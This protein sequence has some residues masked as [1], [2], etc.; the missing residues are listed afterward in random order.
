[1]FSQRDNNLLE[2]TGHFLMN[3]LGSSRDDE[4]KH[5]FKF[6]DGCSKIVDV[7]CGTGTFMELAP[8]RMSGIDFNPENIEVCKAKGLDAQVG[9]ALSIP[10]EDNS[11]DGAYC[12]HLMQVFLPHQAAKLMSELGRVVKPGGKIIIVTLNWFERFFRHP[13]NV[14]AYP[15]DAIHRYFARAN[16]SQSPM[17]PGIPKMRQEGIWLRR[18]PLFELYSPKSHTLN[19]IYGVIS[20]LQYVLML[21]KY[22]CFDAYGIMLKNLK[23][24]VDVGH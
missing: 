2:N 24:T 12:S 20:R 5:S 6:F 9:D 23:E 3:L 16:G 10:F 4:Y 21:R 13:E 22:W 17:F 11:F 15:P 18:A 7:G 8:D 14:R 1:M 19:R